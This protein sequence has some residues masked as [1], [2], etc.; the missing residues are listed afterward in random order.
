MYALITGEIFL[1]LYLY[2]IFALIIYAFLDYLVKSKTGLSIEEYSAR[3]KKWKK[4]CKKLNDTLNYQEKN[5][6]DILD[7]YII[8]D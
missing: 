5:D 1:F 4:S 8:K 7:T 6:I 3:L 2:T